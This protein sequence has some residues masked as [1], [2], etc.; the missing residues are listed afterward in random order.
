CFSPGGCEWDAGWD[1]RGRV[2]LSQGP[3]ERG[4]DRVRC[5]LYPT[6]DNVP[7]GGQSGGGRN[8]RRSLFFPATSKSTVP[9]FPGKNHSYGTS[10]T[11][12]KRL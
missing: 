5:R 1:G 7:K 9:P 3:L 12:R 10:T 6:V 4:Y 2:S 11:I 8:G